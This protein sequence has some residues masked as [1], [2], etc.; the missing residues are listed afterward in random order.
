MLR[1]NRFSHP[2]YQN[3]NGQFDPIW[4]IVDKDNLKGYWIGYDTSHS[5]IN[6]YGM[7]NYDCKFDTFY[8]SLNI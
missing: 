6:A 4:D 5:M 8:N 3:G 7:G 2:G 1:R